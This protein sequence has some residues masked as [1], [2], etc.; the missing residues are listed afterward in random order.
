[1][2]SEHSNLLIVLEVMYV[3]HTAYLTHCLRFPQNTRN[4]CL[5]FLTSAVCI[6]SSK[7]I[8]VL[9]KDAYYDKSGYQV[10]KLDRQTINKLK[11]GVILAVSYEKSESSTQT[12]AQW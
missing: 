5:L 10:S 6:K 7:F 9:A 3:N 2:N 4:L 1:M 12:A 8:P 11:A